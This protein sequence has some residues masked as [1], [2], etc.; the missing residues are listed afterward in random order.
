[1]LETVDKKPDGDFQRRPKSVPK[2]PGK[3]Q[4]LGLRFITES[5]SKS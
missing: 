3:V 5:T 4:R 1:M 2:N